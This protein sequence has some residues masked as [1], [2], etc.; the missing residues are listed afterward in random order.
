ML[1]R[2]TIH[3][4]DLQAEADEYP[5]GSAG[6]VRSPDPAQCSSAA[7]GRAIGAIAIRR[8]EVRPFTDRQIELL[9]IF[10]AQAVIAIE[11]V[12]LFNETKEA[13][14]QQTAT[15]EILRVISSSPTDVQPVLTPSPKT[16]YASVS[17]L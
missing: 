1:D 15:S 7:R 13:L 11:N 17:R 5:E 14:E 6:P 10:A 9:Q 16:P 3:V 2:R 4:A 12:R 8:T